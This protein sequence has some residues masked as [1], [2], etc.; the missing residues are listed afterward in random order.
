VKIG[1]FILALILALLLL[2]SSRAAGN[3]VV[4]TFSENSVR[5]RSAQVVRALGGGSHVTGMIEPSFGYVPVGSAHVHVA[6]YGRDKK[7]LASEI[8]KIKGYELLR[9]HLRPQPRASYTVFF[10]FEPSQIA[11]V[12]IVEHN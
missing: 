5:I 12:T 2:G 6:A 9:W 7:L 10:P 1:T 11:Y 3:P 8:D 4:S